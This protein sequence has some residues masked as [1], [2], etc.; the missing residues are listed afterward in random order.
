MRGA[1]R[2]KIIQEVPEVQGRVYEI[3]V[4]NKDTPKPY[5]ILKQG[6]DTPAEDWLGYKRMIDVIIYHRRST[7]KDLDALAKKVMGALDKQLIVDGGTQEAFT[8]FFEKSS[9]DYI[10]DDWNALTRTLTFSVL[11]L[12]PYIIEEYIES[13][14]AVQALASYTREMLPGLTVYEGV[15]PAGY[16]LPC[17]LWRLEATTSEKITHIHN[18]I[19]KVL[20]GHV[21]GRTVGEQEEIVQKVTQSLKRIV[22]LQYLNRFYTIEDVDYIA[23]RDRFTEGQIQ[24]K[25]F[26]LDKVSQDF[27]KIAKVSLKG[28]ILGE[29]R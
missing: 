19:E 9:T 25:L 16:L 11:G 28:G 7:F 23:T 8:C 12:R 4:P 18:K 24:V 21:I 20:R 2:E 26:Y 13:D 27:P 29:Q 10:D 6:T 5:I 1:I 17:V 22:K 14:E 3:Q 15:F